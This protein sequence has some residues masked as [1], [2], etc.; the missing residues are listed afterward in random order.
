M[1]FREKKQTKPTFLH[2]TVGSKVC[3]G[4]CVCIFTDFSQI[5]LPFL[6]FDTFAVVWHIFHVTDKLQEYNYT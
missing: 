4:L 3:G 6:G 1:R 2:V 5:S